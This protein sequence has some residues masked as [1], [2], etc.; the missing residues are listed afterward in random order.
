MYSLF[1]MTSLNFMSVCPP[2]L[3]H[4]WI[5]LQSASLRGL[6]SLLSHAYVCILHVLTG[7]DAKTLGFRGWALQGFA[8]LMEMCLVHLARAAEF[9]S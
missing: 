5:D 3:A 1:H 6:P 8:N 4:I 7:I 9:Q 2:S